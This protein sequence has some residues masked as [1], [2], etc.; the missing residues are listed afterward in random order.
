[1]TYNVANVV[2][3]WERIV[4]DSKMLVRAPGQARCIHLL[5]AREELH[6]LV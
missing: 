5:I 3:E 2:F 1:M 6:D 4:E